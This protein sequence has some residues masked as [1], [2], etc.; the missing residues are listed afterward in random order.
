MPT[1]TI[2]N[3]IN[4]KTGT[5]TGKR[6]SVG[7]IAGSLG[8]SD[9][10]KSGTI[11]NCRNKGNIEI[12]G[13]GTSVYNAGG[14]V[15]GLSYNSQIINSAN[16]GNVTTH[17]Y[18]SSSDKSSYTG[19]ICGRTTT[20]G[21][22]LIKNCYNTGTITSSYQINGG[23][24]GGLRSSAGKVEHCY[25]VGN[26]IGNTGMKYI[27]AIVGY[28]SAGTVENICYL[29]NTVKDV[30]GSAQANETLI[31]DPKDES[32]LKGITKLD[33]WK[34][35]FINDKTPNINNGWPILSWQ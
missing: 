20:S 17:G 34:D 11:E 5:V 14:I 16:N 27:G 12:T 30:N 21:S 28:K 8:T 35:I 22:C 23:V 2:K 10:K 33:V 9:D 1:G 24:L 3:C 18:K 25:S 26:V 15:G 29:E 19:G 31:G 32:N 7:G 13:T 4:E 6:I